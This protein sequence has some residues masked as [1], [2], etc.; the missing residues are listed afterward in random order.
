MLHASKP[1]GGHVYEARYAGL[2]PCKNYNE[3]S[4]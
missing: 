4:H 3:E 2:P 1:L